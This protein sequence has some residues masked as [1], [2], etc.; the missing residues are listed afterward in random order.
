MMEEQKGEMTKKHG[1]TVGIDR[2]VHYIDCDNF[3]GV[4]IS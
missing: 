2:Y 1:E 4:Y 3:T